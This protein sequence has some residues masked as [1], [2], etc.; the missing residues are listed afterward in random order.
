M[1][2]YNDFEVTFE[3]TRGSERKSRTAIYTGQD[4]EHI[5]QKIRWAFGSNV[6][7]TKIEELTY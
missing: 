3:Y 6:I 4:I 2:P 5:A 1:N 7:I